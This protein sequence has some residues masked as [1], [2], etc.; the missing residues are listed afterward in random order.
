MEEASII[1]LDLAKNV[2]QAHGTG[3]DG[4]VIFRRALSR[5][6]LGTGDRRFGPR[7]PADPGRLREALREAAGRGG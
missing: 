2:S 5:A 7:G 6:P 3:A 1:G 4:L